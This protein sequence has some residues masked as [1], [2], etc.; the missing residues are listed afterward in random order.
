MENKDKVT[1]E[2]RQYNPDDTTVELELVEFEDNMDIYTF[3]DFCKR[4][5]YAAGYLS[6]SIET[7]F[8]DPT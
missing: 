3:F 2:F 6:S 1:I 4:F 8:K 7:V 5:A